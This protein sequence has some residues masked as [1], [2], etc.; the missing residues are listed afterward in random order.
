MSY[1]FGERI[2]VSSWG[3]GIQLSADGFPKAKA[4]GVHFDW[5]TV[6]ALADD[7]FT[8]DQLDQ[9]GDPVPGAVP[10]RVGDKVVRFGTP[11]QR[12]ASDGHFVLALTGGPKARGDIY[13]V[14]ETVCLKAG[15]TH[16]DREPIAIDG[17]RI[18]KDRLL[19]SGAD[20]L[21]KSFAA[22]T[23]QD[24]SSSTDANIASGT[25]LTLAE[26]EAALPN[27]TYALD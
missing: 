7:T 18:F 14:N 2:P 11:I 19:V 8:T 1:N 22:I 15:A 20:V 9:N 4:G 17:G 13:L 27:I 21:G 3:R 24:G 25:T 6:S 23:N 5:S 10:Y 12:R 26:L 16:P